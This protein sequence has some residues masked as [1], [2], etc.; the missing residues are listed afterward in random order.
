MRWKPYGASL[1]VPHSS[2]MA[3]FFTF[4]FAKGIGGVD[5][6][7]AWAHS[8]LFLEA[9][10][11]VF[12]STAVLAE[13]L[14]NPHGHILPVISGGATTLAEVAIERHGYILYSALF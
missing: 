13:L 12:A 11:C 8:A 1:T 10:W 9:L 7:A 4:L 5:I 14:S 2:N 6:R 3:I